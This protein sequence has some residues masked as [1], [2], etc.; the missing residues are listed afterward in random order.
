MNQPVNVMKIRHVVWILREDTDGCASDSVFF[1]NSRKKEKEAWKEGSR[2]LAPHLKRCVKHISCPSAA[3]CT[4]I[5][6]LLS[7]QGCQ[8]HPEGLRPWRGSDRQI[9]CSQATEGQ[10]G[11]HHAPYH[12]CQKRKATWAFQ[13]FRVSDFR[14][15]THLTVSSFKIQKKMCTKNRQML[16]SGR[17]RL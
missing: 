6:R 4:Y 15:D 14:A 9:K 17:K 2:R 3:W 13:R 11:H 5:C 7:R 12:I 8:R 10:R 1:L 16:S